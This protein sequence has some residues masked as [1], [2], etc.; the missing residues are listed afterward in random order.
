MWQICPLIKEEALSR[1]RTFA[2]DILLGFVHVQLDTEVIREPV[3]KA[4][5]KKLKPKK[6]SDNSRISD[7]ER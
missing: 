3:I 6:I 2:I 5:K 1:V 4:K 7:L